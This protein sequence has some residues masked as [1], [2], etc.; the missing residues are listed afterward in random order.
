MLLTILVSLALVIGVIALIVA[1][2]GFVPPNPGGSDYQFLVA[3]EKRKKWTDN[4]RIPD[5]FSFVAVKDGIEFSR[6]SHRY[7]PTNRTKRYTGDTSEH[8]N[9]TVLI[10]TG[11]MHPQVYTLEAKEG[12]FF[13]GQTVGANVLSLYAT[14]AK[15]F[16]FAMYPESAAPGLTMTLD[17]TASRCL[18]FECNTTAW[19]EVRYDELSGTSTKVYKRSMTMD[20]EVDFTLTAAGTGGGVDMLA[21]F[22]F[23]RGLGWPPATSEDGDDLSDLISRCQVDRKAWILTP[24]SGH[25]PN[26][27]GE[28]EAA[29][30]VL[31]EVNDAN[32]YAPVAEG[33]D[34]IR[35]YQ[36]GGLIEGDRAMN[37]NDGP[38][39][40]HNKFLLYQTW[41][42]HIED[43]TES[44][45]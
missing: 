10:E 34:E 29:N 43:A 33:W 11:P 16:G 44:P 25:S 20:A 1:S 35:I 8:E 24:V 38:Q 30:W 27:L 31:H 32:N 22:C 23:K 39:K 36:T 6:H 14:D 7:N 15:E 4:I 41:T 28:N 3:N 26:D 2:I 37:M 45:F 13:D 19:Y 9:R 42:T 12:A 17:T 18:K 40:M 5:G 21:V